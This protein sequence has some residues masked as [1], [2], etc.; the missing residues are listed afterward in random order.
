MVRT[1]SRRQRR[2]ATL[3]VGFLNSA[4][5]V[6]RE[7]AVADTIELR[8]TSILDEGKACQAKKGKNQKLR[9]SVVTV[10]SR[11]LEEENRKTKLASCH[12]CLGNLITPSYLYWELSVVK[13][14]EAVSRC[15]VIHVSLVPWRRR[16]RNGSMVGVRRWR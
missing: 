6:R 1:G 16:R 5:P 4:S 10:N 3:W 2:C 12:E 7:R 9:Y 8:F 14:S 13:Y 11:R 15:R